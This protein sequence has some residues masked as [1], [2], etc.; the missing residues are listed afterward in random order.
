MSG[1]FST[2]R[3]NIF[4]RGAEPDLGIR[5]G[6]V[7]TEGFVPKDPSQDLNILIDTEEKKELMSKR[8]QGKVEPDFAGLGEGFGTKTRELYQAINRAEWGGQYDTERAKSGQYFF[9]TFEDP[10]QKGSSAYGPLQITGGL[11]ASNFGD[12]NHINTMIEQSE[13]KY[14]KPQPAK[15]FKEEYTEGAK[16][17][18]RARLSDR[19]KDFVDALL[20]QANLF[21]IFGK[22][23]KSKNKAIKRDYDPKFDYG[24]EGNIKETFPD[25]KQ[26]YDRIG[27]MLIDSIS[28]SSKDTRDFIKQ[29]SVGNKPNKKPSKRY[30]KDFFGEGLSVKALTG[31]EPP[32]GFLPVSSPDSDVKF[33]KQP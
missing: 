6:K 23:S 20:S 21:L 4:R 31:S 32:E 25:Y 15:K 14:D 11:L 7:F 19:E 5:S 29:W 27:Y 24:G 10:T 13:R 12:L 30:I 26:L 1:F 3:D 18:L 33:S 22:E 2:M 8:P 28:N 17:T 16:G 9:R